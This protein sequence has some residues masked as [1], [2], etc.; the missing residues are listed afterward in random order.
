MI[1]QAVYDRY[2]RDPLPVRLG[3]LAADLARVVSCA[4]NPDNSRAVMS[5][6]E[7]SKHFAEWAAG[8]APVEIQAVLAEVQLA[9]ALWQLH[10]RDGH[11]DPH[12]K[13]HAQ[14]W[15]DRLLELSGLTE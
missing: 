9:V 13:E 4:E 11:P 8:D 6:L 5:L 2:M 3:G 1:S 7:E 10:W 14:A 15:S 12:M